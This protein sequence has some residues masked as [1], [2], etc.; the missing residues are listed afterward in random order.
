L[1]RAD[2]FQKFRPCGKEDRPFNYPASVR[3]VP[4]PDSNT[5]IQ[6][7]DDSLFHFGRRIAICEFEGF[8]IIFIHQTIARYWTS[9]P[10]I[11]A[12]GFLVI[13]KPMADVKDSN[14]APTRVLVTGVLALDGQVSDSV[15]DLKTWCE[16]ARAAQCGDGRKGGFEIRFPSTRP[17][18][19]GWQGVTL[20]RCATPERPN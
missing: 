12:S 9:L 13:Q 18:N 7:C 1:G 17:I 11:P 10:P 20:R 15:T 8:W 6:L 14:Q 16:I 5:T 2:Q 3:R 19:E 4:E